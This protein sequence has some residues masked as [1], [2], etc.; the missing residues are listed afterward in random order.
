MRSSHDLYLATITFLV[1]ISMYPPPPPQYRGF[2]RRR[3]WICSSRGSTLLHCLSHRW[4]LPVLRYHEI[5]VIYP[6]PFL[7]VIAQFFSCIIY[8]NDCICI[9]SGSPELYLFLIIYVI[10]KIGGNNSSL[11]S[12]KVMVNYHHH[13]KSRVITQ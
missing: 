12:L 5:T 3:A 4:D 8:I 2:H 11:D 9:L 13:G 10:Q 6:Y 7:V 1:Q